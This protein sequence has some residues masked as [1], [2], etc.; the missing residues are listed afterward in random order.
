MVRTIFNRAE[1]TGTDLSCWVAAGMLEP[2]E[3]LI[4]TCNESWVCKVGWAAEPFY[5]YAYFYYNQGNSERL[6]P[7]ALQLLQVYLSHFLPKYVPV[8]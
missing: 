8:D 3:L 2:K 4:F 1:F 7:V 6:L 5:A